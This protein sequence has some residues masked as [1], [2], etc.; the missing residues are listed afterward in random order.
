MDAPSSYPAPP[1]RQHSGAHGAPHARPFRLDPARVEQLPRRHSRCGAGFRNSR[2]RSLPTR[3]ARA[4][5]G[6]RCPTWR[7]RTPA[8]PTTR[9]SA[10]ALAPSRPNPTRCRISRHPR[11]SGR[12][13]PEPAN[14]RWRHR[15]ARRRYPRIRSRGRQGSRQRAP[16]CSDTVEP[17]ARMGEAHTQPGGPSARWASASSA[18]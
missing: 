13:G 14:D 16:G 6:P 11:S 3:R 2:P 17:V 4:R 8:C 15:I 7:D 18:T 5:R 9:A 10:P 12:E 1:D